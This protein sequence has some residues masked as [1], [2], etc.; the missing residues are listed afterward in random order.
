[1]KTR[2]PL[3]AALV[4]LPCTAAFADEGVRHYNRGCDKFVRKDYAGA[5]TDFSRAIAS[6][7]RNKSNLSLYY[8]RRGLSYFH[9]GKYPEAIPDF[10]TSNRLFP[11]KE[12]QQNIKAARRKAASAR[13]QKGLS[14]MMKKRFRQALAEYSKA[15]GYES[16]NFAWWEGRARAKGALRDWRGCLADARQALKLDP[17]SSDAKSYVAFAERMLSKQG[18]GSSSGTGSLPS[19]A[20]Q[21]RKHEG[22]GHTYYQQRRY[23]AAIADYTKAIGFEPNH[24]RYY[25]RAEAK[26]KLKEYRGAIA[27]Y[28]RAL[29]YPSREYTQFSYSNRG[30]AH[31]LVGDYG[32]AITDA[33]AAIAIK[34]TWNG[35]YRRGMARY[36]LGRTSGAIADFT[37]VSELAKTT[38]LVSMG[39]SSR[40][41]AKFVAGNRKGALPDFLKAL[42]TYPNPKTSFLPHWIAASGGGTSR[43]EA[44]A[45]R[46]DWSGSVARHALGRMSAAA[47]LQEARRAPP[48]KV[49]TRLYVA[50]G[51]IGLAAE[52][53][54]DLTTAAQH[55]RAAA[56]M[57]TPD[58]LLRT[59]AIVRLRTLKKTM[60]S[61]K[62]CRGCS[63][64][65]TPGAKFCSNC[66]RRAGPPKCAGCSTKLPAGAKFCSNCGRKQ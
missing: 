66:G 38:S 27:D 62:S 6:G 30:Y 11:R 23:R 13:G 20:S 7:S 37:K 26:R 47:L 61:A 24:K 42:S 28:G 18:T 56:T 4:L 49:K 39:Y 45:R 2:L 9:L 64:A 12:A 1:M 54:G 58:G 41:R 25:W 65:L 34:G 22:S 60:T 43:L 36:L 55:Y 19:K 35:Y 16:S 3:I 52:R 5:I 15:I 63:K 53:R 59:Y 44:L 40:A 48:S 51:Y 31:Y 29:R 33:S 32:H 14:L 8:F 50:R 10:V 17:T 21:A 46:G 57:G